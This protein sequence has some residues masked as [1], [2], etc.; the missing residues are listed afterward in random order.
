MQHELEKLRYP[1]GRF[2]IPD[3]IDRQLLGD[4]I[5]TIAD[6][7]ARLK[8][9]VNDL[10][11][12]AL[13]KKYRPDGW[14]IRQVIHHC[15]DSHMNSFIRF[16]LALTEEHPII[17]LYEEDLWAELPDTKNSPIESA[18]K[19]LEGLHER[20]EILLKSLTE[21]QLERAF[22]HPATKRLITLKV[23]VGLYAWHCNH[24]LMHIVN[25]KNR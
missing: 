2:A 23:N 9:E 18:I 12:T 4:W 24:H 19:L 20:W 3:S 1:I 13:E 14:T 17:K 15:A 25:A 7:P 5:K 6:F 22:I 10:T 8:S 21:E 16:K 11:D